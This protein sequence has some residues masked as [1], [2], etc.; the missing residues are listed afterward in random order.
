MRA[1]RVASE[2]LCARALAACRFVPWNPSW[3]RVRGPRSLIATSALRGFA[4]GITLGTRV[5]IEEEAF[6]PNQELDLNLAV[7]EA[8]H[9]VQYVRD[10]TFGFL[11]RYLWEYR[12]N[13][14]QGMT[15]NQAYRAISYEVEAYTV[16]DSAL[17]FAT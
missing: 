6:G 11:T 3:G 15:Q 2:E 13:L 12:K 8:T 14:S 7:H 16:G 5:F 17:S 10:G 4:R 1:P 9:V